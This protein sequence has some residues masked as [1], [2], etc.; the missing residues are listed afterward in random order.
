MLGKSAECD[1]HE[2]TE[3]YAELLFE[4]AHDFQIIG[5][6]LERLNW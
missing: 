3:T 2:L 5:C 6:R 4:K 1:P